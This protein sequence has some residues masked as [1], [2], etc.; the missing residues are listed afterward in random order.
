MRRMLMAGG[1]VAAMMTSA[2]PAGAHDHKPPRTKLTAPRVEQRGKQ[3]TYCW[4]TT[5]DEPGM[6]VA[7]CADYVY[8]WPRAQRTGGRKAR[9]RIFK[10]TAP[11]ELALHSWRRVDEN[12]APVGDG[13]H[14]DVSV[15]PTT[16]GASVVYDVTF[17]L[18]RKAGHYYLHLFG[19]WEDTEGAGGSQD[20]SW[21]FHLKLR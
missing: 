17:R 8:A 15:A 9:I 18:P 19:K 5:A 7:T 20:S 13:R 6:Y 12:K 21:T 3:S 10:T 16:V 14:V 11:E 1:L 4:T 2:V